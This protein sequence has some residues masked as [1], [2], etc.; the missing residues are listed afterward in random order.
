MRSL[1]T[2]DHIL[3]ALL[4]NQPAS[5]YALRKI[6][7]TTPMG[8]HS[9]SPGS[10][11]PAL[12]R[13]HR[14]ALISPLKEAHAS[15]RRTQRFAVTRKGTNELHAWL[16]RPITRAEVMHKVDDLMLRFVFRA[17][18]FGDASARSFAAEFAKHSNETVQDLQSYLRGPGRSL[19]LAARLAVEQGLEGYRALARWAMRA[20]NQL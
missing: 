1:T 8:H 14:A 5:G 11:Y 16:H 17:Q 3:L 2:L 15:G 13:L 18:M 7:A 10:I 9:D 12:W 4:A 6:F 20:K 19:P